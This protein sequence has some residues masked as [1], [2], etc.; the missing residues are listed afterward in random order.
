M[1]RR[2]RRRERSC[3]RPSIARAP[4]PCATSSRTLPIVILVTIAVGAPLAFLLSRSIARPL[5]RLARRTSELV[6]PGAP[7]GP[8]LELAGPREVREAT[9]RVNALADEL[10][11]TRARESELLAD[12][13]HDLRTPLTVIAGYAAALADGTARGQA[14]GRAAAAIAEEAA[15]LERLVDELG[16]IDRLRAGTDALRPEPIDADGVTRGHRRPVHGRG[17]GGRHPARGGAP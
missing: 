15:R 13:R 17:A 11:R 1:A 16:A 8:P 9:G 3:S 7:I 14:A 12:L 6:E 5:E 10:S 4:T 2:R